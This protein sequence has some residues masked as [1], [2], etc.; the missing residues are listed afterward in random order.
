MKQ[1]KK[2]APSVWPLYGRVVQNLVVRGPQDQ[3]S[4]PA[5]GRLQARA[6]SV[7]EFSDRLSQP[8]P[9]ANGLLR[10]VLYRACFIQG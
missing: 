9:A 8:E 3:A 6:R 7:H 2:D 10:P 1:D 5:P 4:I